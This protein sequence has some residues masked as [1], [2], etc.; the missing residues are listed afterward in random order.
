MPPP[1]PPPHLRAWPH[2]DALLVDRARALGELNRRLLGGG[3]LALFLT[4]PALLQLGW[5]LVVGSLGA[6]SLSPDPFT[7]MLVVLTVAA[8]LGV[9][10]PAVFFQVR[11]LRRDR[12]VRGRLVQWAL[13]DRDPARDARHRAPV[14]S[15]AWLVV[16]FLMCAAGLWLC[17]A[18]PAAARPGST[19]Y[20]DVA[21]GM[22][23]G[24]GLWVTGLAG[25][26]KA[27]AHYRLA[28]RV[29]GAVSA[30]P[31]SEPVPT[32]TPTPEPAPDGRSA[33]SARPPHA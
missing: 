32:P 12:D 28:V 26:A 15:A 29:F 1:P 23:A 6:L 20:T 25:L 9:L 3:R 14:L 21:Y 11:G 19:T 22:G 16:S 17:F 30:R 4:W 8:G 31:A 2:R 10:V 27:V 18:V 7:L 33:S 24:F 5:A 13:L